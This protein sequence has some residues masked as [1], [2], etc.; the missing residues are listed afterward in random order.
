[1]GALSW[2]AALD[3]L[4]HSS[5]NNPR[6]RLLEVRDALFGDV[7][8]IRDDQ[9][10]QGELAGLRD[11]LDELVTRPSSKIALALLRADVD[12]ELLRQL[13]ATARSGVDV[14]ARLAE[15]FSRGQWSLVQ[16]EVEELRAQLRQECAEAGIEATS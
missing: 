6:E 9:R 10:T 2:N 1:M 4:L 8:A 5:S 7:D 16:G 13:E 12:D 3:V 11:Y 14:S 15:G